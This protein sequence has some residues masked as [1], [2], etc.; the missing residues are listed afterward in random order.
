MSSSSSTATA[1]SFES[2]RL[3]TY[4]RSG[5]AWRVRIALNIK[6]LSYTPVVVNIAPTVSEQHTPAWRTK[7]PMG[8]VPLLEFV[9]GSLGGR[10]LAQSIAIIELLDDLVAVPAL[11]PVEPWAK[12]QARMMAEIVNSGTQPLQNLS[13]QK[14]LKDAGADA[15]AWLQRVIGTGLSALEAAAQQSAGEF[16]VGDDVS[17]ADLCLVPQ[18]YAARRFNVPLEAYK[19]LLAVE[20][21]CAALPAFAAAHADR[22]PDAPAPAAPTAP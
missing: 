6:G 3:Y 17:V 18:L 7:N 21:R 12:A 19:T 5:S 15:D 10:Q 16:L 14:A 4:W 22:Q 8:Q 11:L 2:L 9:G 13:V 20:A 1:P